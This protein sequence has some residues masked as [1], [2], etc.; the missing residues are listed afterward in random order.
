MRPYW[1]CFASKH[2]GGES[3]QLYIFPL[4]RCPSVSRYDSQRYKRPLCMS[5][6]PDQNN[7]SDPHP[8]CIPCS[9]PFP[10]TYAHFPEYL[11]TLAPLSTSPHNL[12]T[13]AQSALL[14]SSF[15]SGITLPPNPGP[16][17]TAA[18]PFPLHI[19]PSPRTLPR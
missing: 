4:L 7:S 3:S 9:I 17:P 15:H 19:F 11:N 8:S 12:F 16:T 14:Y 13:Q 5:R 2:C 1:A 10:I 6:Y 18:R